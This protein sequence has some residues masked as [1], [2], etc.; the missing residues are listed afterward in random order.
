MALPGGHDSMPERLAEY[1]VICGLSNN[2]QPYDVSKILT[3]G[4]EIVAREAIDLTRYPEPITDIKILS[5]KEKEELP[6]GYHR[7]DYTLSGNYDAI[8]KINMTEQACLCYRRGRDRPPI[9][10]IS[11]YV[12]EKSSRLKPNAHCIWSTVGGRSANLHP[13]LTKRMFL[14]YRRAPPDYGIDEL[15]VTDICIVLPGKQE[16][17]PA[18][19]NQI[20]Q[21]LYAN[22]FGQ[23]AYMCYR[24][25]LIKKFIISYEPEVL[26]WYR[27][28]K[29]LSKLNSD[30]NDEG[31]DPL[32]ARPLHADI[33]QVA[34]FCLPWGASIESWSVD[35]NYPEPACFTFMLTNES[36]QR[37][38]GVAFTFYEPYSIEDLDLD[39]CYRLGV[40]PELV[41]AQS[42][43]LVY[44]T[45]PCEPDDAVEEELIRRRQ[46]H[47]IRSRVGDRVIGVTKTLCLLSRWPFTVAFSNF[48]GFLYSRCL[49]TPNAN[50]IPFERYLGYFL[51]EVPFPSQAASNVLVELCAAPILLQ[52][53]DERSIS[54]SCES[55]FHLLK[56]LGPELCIQLL[57]QM[58]TEQKILMT[59]I[60]HSLLSE[61]GEALTTMIFPLKWTV[62]YVPF[63]YMGCVHVIQSPSPYLIGVDSRFF[64][65]FRL[66]V[67][68]TVAYVDI[69]TRNFKPPQ[70]PGHGVVDSKLLPKK[71]TK[72]LKSTLIELYKQIEHLSAAARRET[73]QVN[74]TQL[75]KHILL[76]FMFSTSNT[77][78]SVQELN[79]VRERLHIGLCI[80]R[81]FL[82]FMAVILKDYQSYLIPVRSA[83]RDVLFN[84]RKFLLEV[85]DKQTHQFYH[86]LFGTQQWANFIRDRSYTS[87]RDEEIA[88]FDNYIDEH[89]ID[90]QEDELSSGYPSTTI[91]SN[92]NLSHNHLFLNNKSDEQMRK[93]STAASLPNGS[94]NVTT[95]LTMEPLSIHF[96][97]ESTLQIGPPEWPLKE[98]PCMLDDKLIFSTDSQSFSWTTD[99]MTGIFPTKLNLQIL[100]YL[101]TRAYVLNHMPFMTNTTNGVST[102]KNAINRQSNIGVLP[103]RMLT[104][105]SAALFS[106]YNSNP[107]DVVFPLMLRSFTSKTLSLIGL[108]TKFP[109][110]INNVT[111]LKRT[112]Q[113]L[114]LTREHSIQISQHLDF[115]WAKYIIASSYSLWFMLFPAY[116]A[117]IFTYHDQV[118]DSNGLTND[119]HGLSA[120]D[121]AITQAVQL[122]KRMFKSGFYV[123]DQ[124]SLRILL[125]LI[126]QH[127][128][129]SNNILE[130]IDFHEWHDCSLRIMNYIYKAYMEEKKEEQRLE[131]ERIS[132]LKSTN[133]NEPSHRRSASD[134][135][136]VSHLTYP[137]PRSTSPEEKTIPRTGIAAK[138]CDLNQTTTKCPIIQNTFADC[139]KLTSQ[140]ETDSGLL[141][142]NSNC[143]EEEEDVVSSNPISMKPNCSDNYGSSDVDVLSTGHYDHHRLTPLNDTFALLE[144]RPARAPLAIS[145]DF[146][147]LG[148]SSLNNK[149]LRT[150]VDNLL[151][152]PVGEADDEELSS[153]VPPQKVYI[154]ARSV[155]SN[156]SFDSNVYAQI[157]NHGS[158]IER[159]GSL[160][161]GKNRFD[162]TPKSD[163]ISSS[164]SVSQTD[165]DSEH[166]N[167]SSIDSSSLSA[168]QATIQ[169]TNL[170]TNDQSS[171]VYNSDVQPNRSSTKFIK[172]NQERKS[173]LK[174]LDNAFNIFNRSTTDLTTK[175]FNRLQT[176]LLGSNASANSTDAAYYVAHSTDTCLPSAQCPTYPLH[177]IG[178]QQG[179]TGSFHFPQTYYGTQ[180]PRHPH[181]DQLSRAYLFKQPCANE[182]SDC[183]QSISADSYHYHSLGR[184]SNSYHCANTIPVSSDAPHFDQDTSLNDH[185]STGAKP[186][187]AMPDPIESVLN[188][189][190]DTWYRVAGPLAVG[191]PGQRLYP[192][193]L[194]T[195]LLKNQLSSSTF[196]S[197]SQK[198]F[199]ACCTSSAKSSPNFCHP[200][201]LSSDVKQYNTNGPT[202]FNTEPSKQAPHTEFSSTWSC[203]GRVHQLNVSMSTCSQCTQCNHLVYDEDIMTRWTVSESDSHTQCPFCGWNFVPRL[204]I[205]IYGEIEYPPLLSTSSPRSPTSVQSQQQTV[206]CTSTTTTPDIFSNP[207]LSS[208]TRLISKGLMEVTYNYLSP[209][210]LRKSLETIL[211]REGDESLRVMSI[212]QCFLTRHEQLAWNLIWLSS[213]LGLP[214]HL[215]DSLPSWL[216]ERQA[217]QRSWLASGCFTSTNKSVARNETNQQFTD[218]LYQVHLSPSLP[219]FVTLRWNAYPLRSSKNKSLYKQYNDL[220]AAER[221]T[222]WSLL[223]ARPM[224]IGISQNLTTVMT[225]CQIDETITQVVLFIADNKMRFALDAL[226][227]L[228]A[229]FQF[230]LPLR[231]THID[232]SDSA[233]GKH[234]ETH[235][236]VD[237]GVTEMNLDISKPNFQ[238]RVKCGTLHHHA[239]CL[240][241]SL[242]RE[243]LFL[244]LTALG[245]RKINMVSFDMKY[246]DV[247]LRMRQKSSQ[248]ITDSDCP[249]SYAAMTCRQVLRELTLIP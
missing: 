72:K 63:I 106:D 40:D 125:V 43:H 75:K 143:E 134:C 60:T 4:E 66:P 178:Q 99:Y 20:P 164:T 119:N 239:S 2:P 71:P 184:S 224:D 28:P 76:H 169:P 222:Q 165:F 209:F 173:S 103:F 111:I 142:S 30:V 86:N 230:N 22:L 138:S 82:H 65:F 68:D 3:H 175:M 11:I 120:V 33:C 41:P 93:L 189:L 139:T 17:C 53:P 45:N 123:P 59:S 245:F 98:S 198:S 180:L 146:T 248:F 137:G 79:K 52:L 158:M 37:L 156:R 128:S 196:E 81:A 1:F 228:R 187:V 162:I 223:P 176:T 145:D 42:S 153:H 55:F 35:Q 62:V 144:L 150:H 122:H 218:A 70:L 54:S 96:D 38:Y 235:N 36:Y 197:D 64:D 140:C 12:E 131:N 74:S 214:T 39:K 127:R 14:S 46:G 202:S 215:L 231:K 181:T 50:P 130:F 19:Y 167:Q 159:G 211:Q 73:L 229:F 183:V 67:G 161:N 148:Y 203:N 121:F 240:D 210:V 244:V 200:V 126:Y 194:W 13:P 87:I 241:D 58:L 21:C 217:V 238:F 113:E 141:L 48:L 77:D 243:L 157:P 168:Y 84:S 199:L 219:V 177:L 25:S 132:T 237:N 179:S 100:D 105:K 88:Y 118:A 110:P 220:K 155:T 213:R 95:N 49:L 80:K 186:K 97:S 242:Y 226:V 107:C 182:G 205:R 174:F 171:S 152:S 136:L 190:K 234:I 101:A 108:S 51:F 26:F 34:N 249:P 206:C 117:L 208:S 129:S 9:T 191:P 225:N 207:K 6:P 193:S 195:F 7:I 69:D 236:E 83:D 10:D 172:V 247:F 116:L 56:H 188:S 27:V 89:V 91:S 102:T 32:Q 29:T 133:D 23:K 160:D 147:D 212:K 104:N 114:R 112:P 124:V 44:S 154:D 185:P 227:R 204:F 5:L 57:V 216:M 233:T 163:E 221:N 24:K 94:D 109:L 78:L 8:I 61:I 31:L 192:G 115:D 149:P 90:N 170:N 47:F 92:I 18:A 246:R 16:T 201:S 151:I 166:F 135:G 15:A 232:S 85:A